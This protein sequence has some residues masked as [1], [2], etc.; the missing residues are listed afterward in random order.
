M[1]QRGKYADTRMANSKYTPKAW[2]T[3]RKRIYI[4]R[5]RHDP[6]VR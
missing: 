4:M 5:P 6:D 2:V 3:L 1:N